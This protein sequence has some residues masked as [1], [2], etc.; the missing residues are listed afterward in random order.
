MQVGDSIARFCV[1]SRATSLFFLSVPFVSVL[2]PPAGS[3]FPLFFYFFAFRAFSLA[4]CRT[5]FLSRAR[6]RALAFVRARVL[7][8]PSRLVFPRFV[9]PSARSLSPLS[10][11]RPVSF[12]FRV[13]SPSPFVPFRPVSV[14][15]G[16]RRF[17]ICKR[18]CLRVSNELVRRVCRDVVCFSFPFPR[19][20]FRFRSPSRVRLG[21]PR[22]SP[23]AVR[24][25]PRAPLW[26]LSSPF[27]RLSSPRRRLSSLFHRCVRHPPPFMHVPRH[28]TTDYLFG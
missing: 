23:G 21:I 24:G 26:R 4:F 20:F 5:F 9:F 28:S 7:L 11:P 18:P 1:V 17:R 27:H 19:S 16:P 10:F 14:P 6:F 8:F 25:A 15:L 12:S 3:L 13:A 22:G 2:P